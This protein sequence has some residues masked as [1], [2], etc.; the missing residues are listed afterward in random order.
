M[1]LIAA[2]SGLAAIGL[3]ALAVVAGLLVG[4]A[5]RTYLF[6]RRK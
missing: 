3:L 6:S 2:T 1:T 4:R 5:L